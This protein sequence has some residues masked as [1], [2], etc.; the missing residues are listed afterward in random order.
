M[1]IAYVDLFAG[2][3]GDMTLGALVDAGLPFA[4]LRRGLATLRLEGYTLA[5]RTVMK[6]SVR[7]TKV[8]VR[9]KRHGHHHTP[10]KA[11][12]AR[13]RRSG[14][15]AAAKSTATEVFL[16]LGVAE[17]RIHGIDPMKVEFHEVGAVDSIVD[18]VGSCL[19]LHLLGIGRLHCSR[20]PVAHGEIRMHHGRLPNPGPATLELLRGFPIVPV[21][22]DRELVTPTGAAILAALA[23]DPGRV[24][25][26][27][28]ESIGYGAGEMDLGERPNIVRILVG[29]AASPE[30]A[31]AVYLLETNL[32]NVSGELVGYLFEKLF[33]AGAVDVYTTAIQMKKSRPAVKLSVL[34]PPSR[35]TAVEDLLL[36]ETP[37]FGV[38]R[39]LMDRTK[40]DR[41]QRAVETPFG[42][43]QVKEGYRNGKLLKAAPEFEDVRAAAERHG[44][45]LAVVR[46]SVQT[47][48]RGHRPH[49]HPH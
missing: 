5:R 33:K 18:I 28:I 29:T 25:E 34:V 10:L 37:T 16:R 24:P 23:H 19:G 21:D 38:R 43:I 14:V 2:L 44:V 36:R 4:D 26:M 32:D 13:I 6:G 39:V 12:L 35:R 3:S 1:K 31:D 11:I 47:R 45:P 22:V 17:G 15:P 49:A 41:H 20:I 46:A 48:R 30:E 9:V 42:T 40:L 27:T 8:D 7:A